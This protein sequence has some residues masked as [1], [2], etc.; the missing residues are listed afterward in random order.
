MRFVARLLR[1]LVSEVAHVAHSPADTD[2]GDRVNGEASGQHESR[3]VSGMQPLGLVGAL[4][5][6]M[7]LATRLR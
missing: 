6:A 2:P 1:Q 5:Y 7:L 3:F 4:A